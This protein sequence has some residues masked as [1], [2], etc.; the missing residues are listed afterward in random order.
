MK[1]FAKNLLI[2]FSASLLLISMASSV[3]AKA[4]DNAIA[5][6]DGSKVSLEYTLTLKD[7]G[8]I[9]NNVGGEPMVF[10]YGSKQVIPGLEKGV[11]G[12]KA[13]DVKKLEI[14]PEDAYGPIYQEAITTAKASQFPADLLQIDA[15]FET[16]GQDGQTYRGKVIS[17]EGE[18]VKVDFNHPLAG[19]TLYFDI[20][21]L[22]VEQE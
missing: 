6:T 19:Q 18:E 4:T 17:I 15:I 5:I 1:I 3:F 12:L 9:D 20:K 22:S 11:A 7:L 21:V 2:L 13:G 14:A 10:V 8:A 16:Q